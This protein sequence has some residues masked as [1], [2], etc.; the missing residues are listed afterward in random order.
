[1]HLRKVDKA[2]SEQG[3]LTHTHTCT[4]TLHM[5]F[6]CTF[7][8]LLHPVHMHASE[9]YICIHLTYSKVSADFCLRTISTVQRRTCREGFS[10]FCEGC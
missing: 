9:I 2:S 8:T 5:S 7:P 6:K 4:Q 10:T 3:L 1:M